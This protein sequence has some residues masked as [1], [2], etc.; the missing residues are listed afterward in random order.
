MPFLSGTYFFCKTFVL[1][2][3]LENM[4]RDEAKRRLRKLGA[5][6]V[7]SVSK[8]TDYVV[9]GEGPGSKADK[10]KKLGVKMLDESAFFK[11]VEEK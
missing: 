11:L 2:G 1:T 6:V 4:S 7:D 5:K 10:A 3:A 9:V 8:K